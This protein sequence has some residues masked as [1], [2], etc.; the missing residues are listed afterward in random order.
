MVK[1]PGWAKRGRSQW[2]YYG[3]K[4]PSFAIKPQNGQESVWDYPCPPKIDHDSRHIIVKLD[5]VLI[6]DTSSAI[7]ILETASPP[8]FYL[9]PN[10]IIFDVLNKAFGSSRCEW[11]GSAEYWDVIT[12]NRKL[13]RVGWSY[14][15]PFEDFSEIAGYLSFYPA[16]LECYIDDERVR[17]QPGG[18]YGGWITN[19]IVGPV[20]GEDPRAYL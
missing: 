20:K 6:V 17:P 19:E 1:L 11:K 16:H 2:E 3:Q 7:R 14:P 10:D 13:E 18:F 4:R 12:S 15:D 9:P 5:D 8:T